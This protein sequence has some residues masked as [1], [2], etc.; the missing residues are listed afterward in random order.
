MISSQLAFLCPPM[1]TNSSGCLAPCM[2]SGLEYTLSI[3][4]LL[5]GNLSSSVS[6]VSREWLDSQPVISAFAGM[7]IVPRECRAI[8]TI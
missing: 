6:I 1:K 2:I 4:W 7:T 5:E 3:P 8:A